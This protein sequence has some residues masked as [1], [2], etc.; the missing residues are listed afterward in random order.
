MIQS[1]V[2]LYDI[3]FLYGSNKLTDII[4]INRT[5]L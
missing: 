4:F 1:C 3:K 2:N 5:S